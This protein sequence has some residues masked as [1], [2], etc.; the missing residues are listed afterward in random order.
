[1]VSRRTRIMLGALLAVVALT[2]M[3]FFGPTTPVTAQPADQAPA[4]HEAMDAMMDAM[5]GPG[6]AEQMHQIPGA[7][8]MMEQCASMMAAMGGAM[9][10]G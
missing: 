2:G 6:T 1:M 10:G 4:T 5:H 7:E 9:M 3:L 8:Q